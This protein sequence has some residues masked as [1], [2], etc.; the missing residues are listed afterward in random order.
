MYDW[1]AGVDGPR[2]GSVTVGADGGVPLVELPLDDLRGHVAL[3]TQE[4]HV[5]R[6]TLRENLV[7]AR[8]DASDA[9][10]ERA[11]SAVDWDGPGLAAAGGSYAA[12]WCS[13]RH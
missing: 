12:L 10:L 7:M 1:L 3:V 8:P 11:L 13:W 4:H 9:D 5:F 6:G 2:A